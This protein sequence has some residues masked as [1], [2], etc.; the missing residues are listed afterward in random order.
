[1][2]PSTLTPR[3]AVHPKKGT[4]LLCRN[5]GHFYFALT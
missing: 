1:M 3:Y 2:A 4:F 5:R